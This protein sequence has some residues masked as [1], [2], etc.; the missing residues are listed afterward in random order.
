MTE[1]L[2]SESQRVTTQ[3][4]VVSVVIPTYNC[5]EYVCDAIDSALAQ[6]YSNIEVIVVDDGSTDETGEM[7][8]SRYGERIKYI[9]QRN[10]GPASARNRAIKESRG[11]LIAFLD[12]DDL[13]MPDKLDQQ[14]PAFKAETHLVGC[15]QQ[16]ES[17]GRTIEIGFDEL[18]LKNR[19]SNS[20]V[21]VRR[22][23]LEQVGLLDERPEFRAVEDWDMW[24]RLAKV[25]QLL[26]LQRNLIILRVTENSISGPTQAERMLRNETAVLKKHLQG[27]P[28]L[29]GRALS[30]CYRSAAWAF[31]ECHKKRKALWSIFWSYLLFPWNILDR[32]RLGLLFKIVVS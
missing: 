10:G 23:A 22:S 11:E 13:W 17:D 18:A 7:L 28:V 19:F 5:K 29:Y 32:R 12:A 9:Y 30:N 2:D 25:G 4:N 26:L 1:L 8:E 14:I 16:S 27:R 6:T 24:L 20:G 15:C 31:I 21:M 3:S